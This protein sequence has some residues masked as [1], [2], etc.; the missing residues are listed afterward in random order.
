MGKGRQT[1]LRDAYRSTEIWDLKTIYLTILQSESF[2]T[3]VGQSLRSQVA[4]MRNERMNRAE[5]LAQEA[6]LKLMIPLLLLIFPV[7]FIILLSP[8]ILKLLSGEI[9]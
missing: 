2:G 8:L 3:P 5:R 4:L 1:A 9:L 6:P 7:T